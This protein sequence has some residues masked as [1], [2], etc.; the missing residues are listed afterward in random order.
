MTCDNSNDAQDASF[1]KIFI[2]LIPG[3]YL[4]QVHLQVEGEHTTTLF[5]NKMKLLA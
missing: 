5:Y 4:I 2:E 1:K 3:F